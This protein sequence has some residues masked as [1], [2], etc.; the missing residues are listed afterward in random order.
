MGAMI[1]VDGS[2][3]PSRYLSDAEK[4]SIGNINNC[5]M[6]ESF[7]VSEDSE[8]TFFDDSYEGLDPITDGVIGPIKELLAYAEKAGF[9][10]NGEI[11]VS[12][13]WKDFDNLTISIKNN[14]ISYENTELRNAETEQLVAELQKR[15]VLP[16]DFE[17]EADI[18]R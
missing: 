7:R 17:I 9:E 10:L 18:E 5:W 15:G 1:Y 3:T 14:E 6:Y 12:S 13:D 2:L 4:Q 11:E 16:M 8:I